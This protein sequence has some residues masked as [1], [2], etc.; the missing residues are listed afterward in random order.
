MHGI[1]ILHLKNHLS[2]FMWFEFPKNWMILS[3]HE[4]LF[5][6]LKISNFSD[7]KTWVHSDTKIQDEKIHSWK[8]GLPRITDPAWMS[9]SYLQQWFSTWD[10]CTARDTSAVAMVYL[11]R[12]WSGSSILKTIYINYNLMKWEDKKI[13]LLM[14]RSKINNTHTKTTQIV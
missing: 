1:E 7:L 4:T 8:F 13:S 5:T 11:E 10:I 6:L 9:G 14:S 3:I 2:E 12:L